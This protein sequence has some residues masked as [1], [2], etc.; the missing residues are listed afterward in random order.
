MDAKKSAV[1][2]EVE[3]KMNGVPIMKLLSAEITRLD[4]GTCE[5]RVPRKKNYEGIFD[6]FH[7]GLITTAADTVAAAAVLT[8]AGAEAVITTTDIHIRFLRPCR[9]D[10]TAEATVIKAGRT[11]CPVDVSLTDTEMEID[12]TF[13]R[14]GVVTVIESKNGFGKDFAVYQIFVPFVFFTELRKERDLA[15]KEVN[16]CYL[17]R[18]RT[19]GRSVLRL[20]LYSFEDVEDMTSIRLI[21]NAE[22]RLIQK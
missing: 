8:V 13:E 4:E 9:S 10:I 15:M 3:R 22:Y 21:R 7:G 20:Y 5:L 17:L 16:A 11:L 1:L 12:Q 19:D 2:K 6:T 14:E 18:E